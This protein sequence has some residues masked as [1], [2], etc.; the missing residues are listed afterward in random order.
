MEIKD[1]SVTELEEF[2]NTV[3]DMRNAQKQYFKYRDGNSLKHSKS[4]ESK[5]DRFL[6][7][8]YANEEGLF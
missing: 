1:L 8:Y 2:F 6:D 5:V 4:I 3:R 7:R